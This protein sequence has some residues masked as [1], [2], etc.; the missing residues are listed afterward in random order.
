MEVQ[1]STHSQSQSRS[2]AGYAS[3]SACVGSSRQVRGSIREL[4]ADWCAAVRMHAHASALSTAPAPMAHR[5]GA[6]AS[7]G[8]SASDS[9]AG[10]SFKGPRPV[11]HA[12]DGESDVMSVSA[13]GVDRLWLDQ[14]KLTR[15]CI[16]DVRLPGSAGCRRVVPAVSCVDVQVQSSCPVTWWLLKAT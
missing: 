4:Y 5:A 6:S 7:G 8:T 11:L 2:E 10:A 1:C 14:L 9:L 16:V 3:A 12:V 15:C 13:V